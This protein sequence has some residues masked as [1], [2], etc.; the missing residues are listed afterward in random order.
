MIVGGKYSEP[1]W[2][3][4]VLEL[5]WNNLNKIKKAELVVLFGGEDIGSELYGEEPK[6]TVVG[7]QSGRDK[8]ESE[9][10]KIA[11]EEKIPI[12]GLCRGA[13]LL[14]VANGGSLWQHVSGHMSPHTITLESGETLETSSLHHQLMRPVNGRILATS[15]NVLSSIKFCEKGGVETTDPEPEIVLF[16]NGLAVQGHPEWMPENSRL[17]QVTKKYLNDYFGVK[18]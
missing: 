8:L 15:T 12:L 14:C 6:Y 2:G 13:Q 7:K 1:L 16:H 11:T 4:K 10:I 5:S 3:W 17:V 9:I 18:L